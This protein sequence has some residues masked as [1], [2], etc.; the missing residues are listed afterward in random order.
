MYLQEPP[1]A[2]GL[3]RWARTDWPREGRARTRFR[4]EAEVGLPGRMQLDLYE[5]TVLDREGEFHHNDVA[6]ELRYAFAEWGRIPLN[7]T[8]YGEYKFANDELGPDVYEL[9]L[10][11]GDSV[12]ENWH[13]GVNLVNEQ[14]T[15]E[16]K[17]TEYQICEA[18]GYTLAD[19]KWSIGEEA[20]FLH[21]TEEGS[22]SDAAIEISVGPSV[23]WRMSESTH[24]DLVALFGCTDDAPA[25][26]TYLC[27]A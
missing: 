27:S 14:E 24:F 2:V 26:E 12:G 21:V 5:D 16:A 18:V 19:R 15:G 7:P 25:L 10:L 23:Q 8:V 13:Y 11:L 1:G 4:T 22:R 9:K 3:E 20:K 6:V 17:A